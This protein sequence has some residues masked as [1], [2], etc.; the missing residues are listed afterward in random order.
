MT[1]EHDYI[2]INKTLWNKRTE[3][4]LASDFYDV[5]GFVAGKSSLNEIELSLLGDIQGKTILH[6]QCHFGQD[7]ISLQRLGAQVTG[8]DL[9]DKAITAAKD[10]AA[11]THTNPSFICCDI[12]DLPNH[13][14]QKFDMV[15]T[16]YGTIGWLPDITKWA[17]V[18]STFLK[19]GGKLLF[20]DFHPVVWMFDDNFTGVG[21]HY[22]NTEAII[23]TENGTYADR[24]AEIKLQS[25]GWNH[26]LSEVLNN[27]IKQSLELTVFNE[28]D[29]APYNCFKESIEVGPG[30]FRI[31]H[32][33]NKI[34]MVYALV[35]VKKN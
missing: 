13:L 9:S 14:D 22:F 34:P 7:S 4:H 24:D 5:A 10:L 27:L 20:A 15:F 12:Y 1:S 16:T 21:Y 6:L 2:Q 35:A 23:E 33:G 28:Y 17:T 3:S 32:L 19:P 25:I 29:Y 18:V 30:K 11:Q 8:V 26:D 31:K